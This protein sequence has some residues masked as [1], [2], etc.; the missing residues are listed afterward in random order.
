MR[1]VWGCGILVSA[2]LVSGASADTVYLKD[3]G[4]V[5]GTEALEEG[6]EIVLIRPTGP[7]RFPKAAVERVEPARISLPRFYSPPADTPGPAARMPAAPG[8]PGPAPAPAPAAPGAPPPPP[9]AGSETTAP[10][11]PPPAELPP[12]PPPP[13]P[14]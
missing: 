10:P 12:P 2:V 14:Q 11:G 7:V 1:W 4:A 8:A 6:D 9:P 13:P 5:W 3:G